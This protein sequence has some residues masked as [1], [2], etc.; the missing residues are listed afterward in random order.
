MQSTCQQGFGRCP[1]RCLMTWSLQKQAIKC[2]MV[3]IMTT[4]TCPNL[5]LTYYLNGNRFD[6]YALHTPLESPF[7]HS[8]PKVAKS[9]LGQHL[10]S[11][12]WTCNMVANP[13]GPLRNL[14]ALA[15][16]RW[17]VTRVQA[18]CYWENGGGHLDLEHSPVLDIILPPK[19]G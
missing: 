19:P 2:I 4:T 17:G 1:C 8:S 6:I 5:L 7:I 3:M 16:V 13:G 15:S 14:L 18:L 10:L 12:A 9:T 11:M